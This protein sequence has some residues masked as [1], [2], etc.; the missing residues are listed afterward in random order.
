MTDGIFYASIMGAFLLLGGE[1]S[2]KIGIRKPSIKKSVKARTTG[3]MKRK[4]KKA[5]IP[6]YGKKG[7]GWIKN[8]KK[9]A[10]N[11]VYNKTSFSVIPSGLSASKKTKR[12][13]KPSKKHQVESRVSS[14]VLP[15]LVEGE[16]LTVKVCKYCNAENPDGA[17]KCSS[18]GASEFKYKCG[19]CGTIF[20]D[21]LYCPTCG[22]KVGQ[23]SKKCPR[24]GKEFY[25]NACPDCG[26]TP[27]QV[28]HETVSNTSVSTV[29]TRKTWLWV[30][31]WIFIF[32]IPLTIIMLRKNNLNKWIRI[33][34][35]IL[36]WAFYLLIG[37]SG[38]QFDSIA[39][40]ASSEINSTGLAV[41]EEDVTATS[42]IQYY[43]DDEAINLF[44]NNYNKANLEYPIT[45]ENI[46]K[47]Y[48]HGREHND[49]IKT[50]IDGFE[51]IIS[52]SAF[53]IEVSIK[54]L[55]ATI[56]EYKT[57]FARF[58]KVSDL[59][60]TDD[61]L[62]EYWEHLFDDTVLYNAEF[63]KFKCSLD[64]TPF[65]KEQINC[66]IIDYKE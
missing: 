2:L 44:L 17:A 39:S 40:N 24:C 50:Q 49:Q 63:D 64:I 32:P 56:K 11:K 25:S 46:T 57:M 52:N 51:I 54:D 18:C 55:N 12:K 65:N 4:M 20:E 8:P 26:Y 60:L 58:A 30:L 28:F 6:G 37:F 42:L 53:G 16:C 23:K 19:N 27:N 36:A 9:A 66:M 35:I 29:K 31:G 38:K 22:V 45:K 47:Y 7:M 33:A 15:E 48:H 13:A 14:N 3:K 5:L 10:Y 1:T 62:N 43:E 34:I 41:S 21:G 59:S 61:E